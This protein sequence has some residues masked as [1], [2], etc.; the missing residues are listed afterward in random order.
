MG[1]VQDVLSHNIYSSSDNS[2]ELVKTLNIKQKN[3]FLNK[4][5]CWE[6]FSFSSVL[7]ANPQE[8]LQNS[9]F[10]LPCHCE[11]KMHVTT[12]LEREENL[13][14]IYLFFLELNTETENWISCPFRK[15][16]QISQQRSSL[17]FMKDYNVKNKTTP[18]ISLPIRNCTPFTWPAAAVS[19]P[20][21]AS[22]QWIP[23]PLH[24]NSNY[25]PHL[26]PAGYSAISL[27]KMAFW[28]YF[29]LPKTKLQIRK[30]QNIDKEIGPLY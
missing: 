25:L 15:M 30:M 12:S 20:Q 6:P 8:G 23:G 1:F 24:W 13:T 9:H 18:K 5:M 28:F 10:F 3:F 21:F 22:V 19:T 29:S 11:N 27:P 2:L 4:T 26:T 16:F 17:F 14:F 7:L